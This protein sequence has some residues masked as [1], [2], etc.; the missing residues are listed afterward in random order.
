[1]KQRNSQVNERTG[2]FAQSS[3]NTVTFFFEG[4][5]IKAKSGDSVAAALL[6]AGELILR[7]DPSGSPRGVVCG[8]GVC[9]ECRCIINDVPNTRACQT[10]VR[11]DMKVLRQREDL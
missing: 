6:E 7:I 4:K 1:M 5:L 10:E 2:C 11:P 8:I 3:T 9:W